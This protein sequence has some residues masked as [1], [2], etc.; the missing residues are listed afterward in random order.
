MTD[1]EIRNRLIDM[2]T[3]KIHRCAERLMAKGLF[4]DTEFKQTL[5]EYGVAA[6]YFYQ[7][8]QVDWCYEWVKKYS[9][10]FDEFLKDIISEAQRDRMWRDLHGDKLTIEN[11]LNKYK[12]NGNNV[13]K[14][15]QQ[16]VYRIA[17]KK[18]DRLTLPY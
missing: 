16:Y 11:Y 6:S 12:L 4:T 18:K 1:K 2:E 14:Y 13:D 3:A 7:L 8:Y 9:M 10:S 5:K 17:F 15:H